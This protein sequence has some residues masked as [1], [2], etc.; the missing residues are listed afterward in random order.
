MNLQAQI[1]LITNP[2][3]FARLY[4]AILIAEYG[5][6]YLVIDDDR[7]D[8]GND[9]YLKSEKRLFAGHCFKRVQNQSIDSEI[10]D[11]MKEDLQKAISLKKE[12]RWDVEAW[13]FLTNYPI[14]ETIAA[15]LVA[16]GR[17]SG[18][19]VSWNGPAYFATFLQKYKNVQEQFPA[20]IVSETAEQLAEIVCMLESLG[21]EPTFLH[22]SPSG[23][24]KTAAQQ[25]ALLKERPPFWE[26]LLF[27]GVLYQG[28]LNL[29]QKWYDH[30][31][32]Y[33]RPNGQRFK[34]T[35]N[36]AEFLGGQLSDVA[37]IVSGTVLA[38]DTVF[39]EQAF[40]APG[41]A[42]DPLRIEYMSRHLLINYEELL[43][44]AAAIRGAS[45]SKDLTNL[46]ELTARFLDKPISGIREFIDD[47]AR[48][49]EK[50]PEHLKRADGEHLQINLNLALT[51]DP[52]IQEA[53]NGE[54]RNLT[55]MAE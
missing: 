48:E 3:D 14:A 31:I 1:E 37:K 21:A 22:T 36:A 5:S 33:A 15:P 12:N 27:A 40:G 10:R 38:F 45:I 19:D 13:T 34:D 54:L 6:D 18:I 44:R 17:E 51:T 8:R 4:N 7:A 47:M 16:L 50:I 2:Q 35:K 39:Q 49:V 29:E 26:Y 30:Q 11:K 43:D 25:R 24:P 55:R 32:H 20:L 9:G 23:V 41:S 42:G 46:F 53:I 28:K 52:V